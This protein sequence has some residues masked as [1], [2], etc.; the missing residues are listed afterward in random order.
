MGIGESKAG[1]V[2]AVELG[3]QRIIKD[4]RGCWLPLEE[5]NRGHLNHEHWVGWRSSGAKRPFRKRCTVAVSVTVM[6]RSM[7]A[8]RAGGHGG[9]V[10]SVPRISV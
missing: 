5:R 2:Q 4:V 6:G 10:G 7:M 9:A 8:N 1:T 3:G